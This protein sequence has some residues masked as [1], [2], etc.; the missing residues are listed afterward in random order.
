MAKKKRT[1]EEILEDIKNY[2]PEMTEGLEANDFMYRMQAGA[3]SD[4]KGTKDMLQTI[5]TPTRP[6]FLFDRKMW[7]IENEYKIISEEISY[8]K[9]IFESIFKTPIIDPDIG[10]NKPHNALTITQ[11]VE[12]MIR[13][14]FSEP[15]VTMFIKNT[16]TMV[17]KEPDN[18]KLKE[19]EPLTVPLFVIEKL[20]K[21]AV[22]L[23]AKNRENH[24]QNQKTCGDVLE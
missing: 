15:E 20:V 16:G 19:I 2:V 1:Y 12:V 3:A 23:D 7:E 6:H 14:Q 8:S 9:I 10:F 13:G 18:D 5:E 22:K 4:D 24:A 17:G 11:I 21:E